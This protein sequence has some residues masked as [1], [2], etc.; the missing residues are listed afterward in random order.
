MDSPILP[1]A[2]P[3]TRWYALQVKPRHERHVAQVLQTKG[4]EQFLPLYTARHRWSD[5]IKKLSLPLFPGYVFCRFHRERR[6]PVVSSPGIVRVVGAGKSPTPID[7]DEI[8]ALQSIVKSELCAHP[9]PFLQV[10]QVVRLSAGPLCG[11]QGILL[12][13]KDAHRL[14]V[15]VNL[16][17]RSVAVQIERGWAMPVSPRPRPPQSAVAQRFT[18]ESS[19]A[20]AETKESRR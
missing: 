3:G 14:I 7:D 5:R 17:Q 8:A 10:G 12:A 20:L 9:F 13:R 15:S 11:L 2:D 18:D 16:L 6:L 1:A 19:F 4:F